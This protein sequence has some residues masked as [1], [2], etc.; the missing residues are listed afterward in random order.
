MNRPIRI[1]HVVNRLVLAG[2]ETMVTNLIL[3]MRQFEQMICVEVKFRVPMA[4]L[5]DRLRA[6]NIR[7]F[8]M[9]RIEDQPQRRLPFKYMQ[10]FKREH[11]DIVHTHS[12]VWRDAFLGAKLA[13]V[14]VHFHTE[15]GVPVNGSGMKERLTYQFLSQFSSRL[16]SVSD[17]LNNYLVSEFQ[18]NPKKMCVIYN[19]IDPNIYQPSS[20]SDDIRKQLAFAPHEKVIG[21]IGRIVALKDHRTLVRAFAIVLQRIPH[22]R[23]LIVGREESGQAG[24]LDD[25]YTLAN[26]LGVG[27][28]ILFIGERSDIPD[29]LNLMDVFVLCS[30]TEG[31]S[32]AILEASATETPVIATKVGGNPR[33]VGD[34]S[35]GFLVP[36][37]S[38]EVLADRL[39]QILGNAELAKSMGK[40][41]REMVKREFTVQSMASRYH[42][43]YLNFV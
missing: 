18:L 38:P 24:V 1:M 9:N 20:A 23:L 4:T 32:M 34:G 29:L 42:Q 43:L 5:E 41:G 8:H 12:G 17:D 19:G 40:A 13:G 27:E 31:T 28:R 35:T 30:L 39:L 11:V 16:I 21:T 22:C 2:L 15:H 25:I 26:G 10:I 36:V 3:N 37:R 6:E 33:I 7:V 14:P